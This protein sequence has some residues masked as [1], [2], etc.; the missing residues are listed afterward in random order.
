[1]FFWSTALSHGQLLTS[2][3]VRGDEINFCLLPFKERNNKSNQSSPLQQTDKQN[4]QIKCFGF[5]LV[6]LVLGKVI[7][8]CLS[9]EHM[10]IFLQCL[11][12]CCVAV[13]SME[14]M[15]A[16]I[17]VN[18]NR[19]KKRNCSGWKLNSLSS[20]SASMH[21]WLLEPKW[22]PLPNSACFS[23]SAVTREKTCEELRS[24]P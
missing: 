11:R 24:A 19:I 1:M 8:N 13:A 10:S 9:Y 22:L 5:Y 18:I 2:V 21:W 15:W 3:S 6:W 4:S 7:R 12:S 17:S 20:S 14:M 16:V 23:A